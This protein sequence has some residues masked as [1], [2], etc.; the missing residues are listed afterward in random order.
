MLTIRSETPSTDAGPIEVLFDATFGPGHFAK[1]AERLREYSVSIAALNRI[2]VTD[3]GVIVGVCRVWPIRI[4]ATPA[5]FYGPVAVAPPHRG[6]R[7][8]L[9][10]TE[11]A[12][13]AGGLAG[14][15]A[16]LL[17]GAPAYFMEIG[18]QP[19]GD[20]GIAMPGPQDPARILIKVLTE[21]VVSLTGPVSAAPDLA[22]GR[23]ARTGVA[24]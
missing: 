10:V 19:A 1:T 11:S 5:L 17:I 18:F 16:A 15:P 12:L 21:P 23:L 9:H 22:N 3:E 4:G 20:M 13:K 8:G 7:L 14:W 24:A 2:A 6:R